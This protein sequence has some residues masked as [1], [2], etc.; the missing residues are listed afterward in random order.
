MLY[1]QII[2]LRLWDTITVQGNWYSRPSWSFQPGNVEN[3]LL[4]KS[5]NSLS[6]FWIYWIFV[7]V[8][9]RE[10]FKSLRKYKVFLL[11]KTCI[12]SHRKTAFNIIV[13]QTSFKSTFGTNNHHRTQRE[14]A[15]CP[16]IEVSA[17]I[18]GITETL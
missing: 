15:I 8:F 5:G 11:Q 6:T 9:Q 4:M 18:M 12:S 7:T 3:M 13:F 1:L 17:P 16:V 14:L 2:Y 10:L